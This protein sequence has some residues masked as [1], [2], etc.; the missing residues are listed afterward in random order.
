MNCQECEV[1]LGME[2]TAVWVEEHLAVCAECRGLA[3]EIRANA[4]GFEAMGNEELA[5]VRGGVM[6][7]I[8]KERASRRVLRWGWALATAAAVVAMIAVS[9]SW[10]EETI[11]IPAVKVASVPSN[12]LVRPDEKVFVLP[13][14][15]HK[16]K[17][18]K[19]ASLMVKMLTD[20]P[21]VVIYWEI[22][23][24]EGSE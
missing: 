14:V 22:G 7:R 16:K 13:V 1:A 12:E 11:V 24:K 10:R 18:Q 20:D 17:L 8:W 19:R 23:T 6:A 2:E 3:E 21:D 15:A 9:R 4:A 5:G